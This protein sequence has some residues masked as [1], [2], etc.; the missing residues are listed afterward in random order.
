MFGQQDVEGH[1]QC[2]TEAVFFKAII[3]F[4]FNILYLLIF[5][6]CGN[7]FILFFKF[8][9]FSAA[10]LLLIAICMT[11]EMFVIFIS[12]ALSFI[13]SYGFGYIALFSCFYAWF[14]VLV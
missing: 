10:E 6:G 14:T 13:S 11:E 8:L 2:I 4:L 5:M 9:Q 12:T 3:L 7:C 1:T